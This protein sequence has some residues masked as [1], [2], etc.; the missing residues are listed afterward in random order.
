MRVDVRE[1]STVNMNAAQETL[2]ERVVGHEAEI[3][4]MCMICRLI[5]DGIRTFTDAF[6]RHFTATNKTLL[7]VHY[8]FINIRKLLRKIDAFCLAT[9]DETMRMPW[10]TNHYYVS[11]DISY[12]GIL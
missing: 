11:Q 7:I 5:W 3:T 10:I 8:A 2:A 6:Y 1:A 12:K 9:R 4:P